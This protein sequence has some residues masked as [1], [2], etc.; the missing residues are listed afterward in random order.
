VSERTTNFREHEEEVSRQGMIDKEVW[1][2][3]IK[4]VNDGLVVA[5]PTDKKEVVLKDVAEAFPIRIGDKTFQG[6]FYAAVIDADEIP[7]AG[8]LA[9]KIIDTVRQVLRYDHRTRKYKLKKD[10]IIDDFTIE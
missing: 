1:E 8:V 5:S 9:D 2:R 3:F 7:D 4:A 10:D 6:L